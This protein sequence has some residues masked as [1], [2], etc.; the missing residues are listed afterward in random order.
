MSETIVLSDRVQLVYRFVK[1]RFDETQKPVSTEDLIRHYF[2]WAD[3]T[4]RAYLGSLTKAGLIIAAPNYYG[5]FTGYY[6][7]DVDIVIETK[8]EKAFDG[9][10][11]VGSYRNGKGDALR[12]DNFNPQIRNCMTCGDKFH[13]EGPHNRM[14]NSCRTKSSGAMI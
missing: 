3:N 5:K 10:Y 8:T 13:S 14:C 7:A 2:Q 6:P 4:V 9:E 11:V 1:K 12:T